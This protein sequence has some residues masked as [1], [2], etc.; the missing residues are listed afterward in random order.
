MTTRS[1]SLFVRWLLSTYSFRSF[2]SCWSSPEVLLTR[3]YTC[4]LFYFTKQVLLFPGIVKKLGYR[5]TLRIMTLV[6][7]AG[8]VLTPFSNSF[9]GPISSNQ[10]SVSTG[11]EGS[12]DEWSDSWAGSGLNST[13]YCSEDVASIN[14]VVNENSITRLPWAVW[15]M[16]A[17]T[18]MLSVI[19][20]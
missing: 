4:I 11:A 8:I 20:R 2:I 16:V 17:G 14:A 13:D 1:V 7:V 19:P 12:G 15:V 18:L 3:T 9:T 5:W 10:S 6:F